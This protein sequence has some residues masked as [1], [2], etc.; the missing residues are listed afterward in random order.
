MSKKLTP[1]IIRRVEEALNYVRP[2]LEADGGDAK[3]L[4]L[5]KDMVLTIEFIGAC[6]SCP[7]S[8]ITLKAGIEESIKQAVPEIKAVE[9]INLVVNKDPDARLPENMAR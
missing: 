9:C 5:N 4:D 2:Y 1:K 8:S 7:M 3:I 6:G